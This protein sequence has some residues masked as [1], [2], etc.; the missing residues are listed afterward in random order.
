MSDLLHPGSIAASR[1]TV[2]V[3]EVLDDPSISG[4]SSNADLRGVWG[5]VKRVAGYTGPAFRAKN[6]ISGI[7]TD[8]Y[9][10]ED[11]Y[12]R[13]NLPF[14]LNTR[15]VVLYDQMGSTDL[16]ATGSG[17]VVVVEDDICLNWRFRFDGTSQFVSTT[18]QADIAPWKVSYPFWGL[19]MVR[20]SNNPTS[21]DRI[22]GTPAPSNWMEY[23]AWVFQNNVHWR[24]NSSAG[25]DWTGT[26][27]TSAEILN[28]H[29]AY[30]GATN[31]AGGRAA[32][33]GVPAG[34]VAAA[35]PIAYISNTTYKFSIG[36]DPLGVQQGC[37]EDIVELILYDYANA[38]TLQEDIYRLSLILNTVNP[39]SYD[40]GYTP[41]Y[42]TAVVNGGADS[43][44]T[45]WTTQEM[46]VVTQAALGGNAFA[47]DRVGILPPPGR[48]T[49]SVSVPNALIEE[50]RVGEL[51]I[52]IDYDIY[53][54]AAG[55]R[56][57]NYAQVS[58]LGENS[59]PLSDSYTNVPSEPAI[60]PN[61]LEHRTLYYQLPP[62]ST[63]VSF[64][65]ETD[66]HVANTVTTDNIF[67]DNIAIT[68]EE[69]PP[70]IQIGKMTTHVVLGGSN[71]GVSVHRAPVHAVLGGGNIGISVQRAP[72]YVIIEET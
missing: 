30:I 43:G 28:K 2:I 42:P 25:A 54:T 4:I 12:L 3:R 40:S 27:G 70:E 67:I 46:V 8:V 9:F 17:V 26:S 37:R 35:L 47:L 24:I 66:G 59:A 32:V 16:V 7:E 14:G 15:A 53:A 65:L 58:I 34:T 1:R 11:G 72:V 36:G 51:R 71:I 20:T 38:A 62:G 44:T 57:W 55:T 68:F 21:D 45:G 69:A 22:F 49:Q 52:K 18:S 13:G 29:R 61:S 33:D 10:N 23:G 6:S 60:T 63:G 41:M 31:A 5:L 39:R 48:L 56:H 19:G 64:R 50:A